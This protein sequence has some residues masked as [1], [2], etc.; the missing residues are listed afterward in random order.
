[1][2]DERAIR[3]DWLIAHKLKFG[4]DLIFDLGVIRNVLKRRLRFFDD[5]ELECGIKLVYKL[6]CI[7]RLLGNCVSNAKLTYLLRGTRVNL[8]VRRDVATEN[9][10]FQCFYV[11]ANVCL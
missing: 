2:V 10:R 8:K 3:P 4:L 7:G 6:Y 1:M 11:A 9:T 5:K